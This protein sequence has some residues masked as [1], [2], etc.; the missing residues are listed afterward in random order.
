MHPIWTL[1]RCAVVASLVFFLAAWAMTAF[2]QPKALGPAAGE[3]LTLD[4]RL[5]ESVCARAIRA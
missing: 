4:G 1:L 5:D 3:R 2:A